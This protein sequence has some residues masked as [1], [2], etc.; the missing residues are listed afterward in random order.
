MALQKHAV[1]LIPQQPPRKPR[2]KGCTAVLH[3]VPGPNTEGSRIVSYHLEVY[4]ENHDQGTKQHDTIASLSLNQ[5][6]HQTKSNQIKSIK[7]SQ[8]KTKSNQ[9]Q[10]KSNQI[11]IKSDQNQI[12]HSTNQSSIQSLNHSINQSIYPYISRNTG[13]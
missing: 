7:S 13:S 9:N 1:K 12:S 6:T 4:G 2:S 11:K 5:T 3:H 8:M 10:I